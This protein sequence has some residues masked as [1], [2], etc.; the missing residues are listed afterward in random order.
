MEAG[1]AYAKEIINLEDELQRFPTVY[2]ELRYLVLAYDFETIITGFKVYD[3]KDPLDFKVFKF[4]KISERAFEQ[5]TFTLI[6]RSIFETLKITDF[7]PILEIDLDILKYAK[8]FL[9]Q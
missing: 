1:F 4:D 5:R 9:P 7:K 6:S 3:F 2:P 8:G